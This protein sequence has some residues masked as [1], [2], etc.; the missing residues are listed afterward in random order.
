M[1]LQLRNN[2][3][4]IPA[5]DVRKNEELPLP[6]TIHVNFWE[7][8]MINSN[9]RLFLEFLWILIRSLATENF[10]FRSFSVYSTIWLPKRV[11]SGGRRSLWYCVY[12]DHLGKMTKNG[13]LGG[14]WIQLDTCWGN[15]TTESHRQ[16]S[17]NDAHDVLNRPCTI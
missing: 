6:C 14:Y 10:K 11:Q 9:I 17:D 5:V 13:G 7:T 8:T 2:V 3:F 1:R 15:G 4:Y 12:Y 16:L